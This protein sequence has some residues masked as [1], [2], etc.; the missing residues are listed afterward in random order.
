MSQT[1]LAIQLMYYSI[2]CFI[3]TSILFTYLRFGTLHA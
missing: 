3:K 1:T 2:V